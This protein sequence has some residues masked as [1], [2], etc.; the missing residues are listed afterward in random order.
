MK[1]I[2]LV[3]LVLGLLFTNLSAVPSSA[4]NMPKT[5]I[6]DIVQLVIPPDVFPNIVIDVECI[7]PDWAD[8][9]KPGEMRKV[10]L[11]I[12][13]WIEKGKIGE[14]L[15]H[16]YRNRVTLVKLEVR[17]V[18]SDNVRFSIEPNLLIFPI[19]EKVAQRIFSLPIHPYLTNK[20]I[21]KIIEVISEQ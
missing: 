3:T 15:L 5:P 8:Q 6:W 4:E 9:L 16:F 18:S 21:N 11:N 10:E 20:Q 2:I 17:D 14:P 12:S 19:S 1:K 7:S 13:F